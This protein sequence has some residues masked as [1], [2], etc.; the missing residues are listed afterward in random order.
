MERVSESNGTLE[1]CNRGPDFIEAK[2][3][4]F[5]RRL[6]ALLQQCLPAPRRVRA[7]LAASKERREAVANMA[8]PQQQIFLACLHA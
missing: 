1:A 4:G 8:G 3:Q 5:G 7:A 6:R 2:K